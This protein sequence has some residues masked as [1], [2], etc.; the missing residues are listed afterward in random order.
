MIVKTARYSL[1]IARIRT[2]FSD[3][4]DAREYRMLVHAASVEEMLAALKTTGYAE[5]L[6]GETAGFAVAIRQYRFSKAERL[7]GSLPA[8]ARTLCLRFLSHFEVAA[9]KVILRGVSAA[10]APRQVLAMLQPMPT[11]SI[12]PVDRLLAS[13]TLEE[14][15]E[16]LAGTP[17]FTPVTEGLQSSESES[18]RA[19]RPN[20]PGT[21]LAIENR[22]DR[23]FL[24]RLVDAGGVFSGHEA[25]ITGRLVNVIV[26]VTNILWAERLRRTFHFSPEETAR[27]LY[28]AGHYFDDVGKRRVLARWDGE[29]QPP[30]VT[31]DLEEIA[32]TLRVSVMRVLAREAYR[33]LFAIPF[34]AGVPLAYLVHGELEV[35][36]L[37]ALHEGRRWGRDPMQLADELIRFHGTS[38]AGGEIA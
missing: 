15:A 23:W 19:P 27:R 4:L 13:K 33:P 18:D 28:P 31:T 16:A 5:P 11:R 17:Y 22:L 37:V 26:D 36:D 25:R 2:S 34:Q 20:A 38:L 29:G 6:R 7:V 9:L 10:A 8:H 21:L 1:P 14:A 30:F 24:S 3:L 35:A 12:L 32:S